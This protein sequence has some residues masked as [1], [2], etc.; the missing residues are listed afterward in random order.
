MIIM[1]LNF[2]PIGVCC[3]GQNENGQW[4]VIAHCTSLILV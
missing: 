4:I 2:A 3:P 1:Q